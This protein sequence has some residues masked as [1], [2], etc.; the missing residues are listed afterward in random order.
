M[1]LDELHARRLATVGKV[2]DAALDR[3]E[4]VLRSAEAPPHGAPSS[5]ISAAC[6]DQIR[7]KMSEIRVCL[8]AGLEHFDVELQKPEPGQMLVAELSALWVVLENNRPERMEGYGR[9][10]AAEDKAAWERLVEDLLLA[11]ERLRG[12]LREEAKA[13]RHGQS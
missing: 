6:A 13:G 8:H 1:A 10:W 9:K 2:F 5:G 4:L 7:E 11:I 3:M 12:L